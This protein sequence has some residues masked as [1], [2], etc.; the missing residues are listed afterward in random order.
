MVKLVGLSPFEKY[1]FKR[2]RDIWLFW[3]HG[4]KGGAFFHSPT[5]FISL[6]ASPV[7]I[8]STMS[9]IRWK[10]LKKSSVGCISKNNDVSTPRDLEHII[11]IKSAFDKHT[12]EHYLLTSEKKQQQ[13]H[14]SFIAMD[15]NFHGLIFSSCLRFCFLTPTHFSRLL[16]H[17]NRCFTWKAL[18]PNFV[19]R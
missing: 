15:T 12:C 3:W 5:K 14:H 4:N 1:A 18:L 19:R 9:N 13:Q 7:L 10:R 8:Q 17:S 16:W 11:W 6:N 2:R